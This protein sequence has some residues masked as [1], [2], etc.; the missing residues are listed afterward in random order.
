MSLPAKYQCSSLIRLY[1]FQRQM[2]QRGWV[3]NG[4]RVTGHVTAISI[5]F[6]FLPPFETSMRSWHPPQ[7]LCLCCLA[8]D[9]PM[10]GIS[11]TTRWQTQLKNMLPHSLIHLTN[12]HT[13]KS[14]K[15]NIPLVWVITVGKS[16]GVKL[17]PGVPHRDIKSS[18]FFISRADLT[19]V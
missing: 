6:F 12:S 11:E 15:C 17:N 9:A 13:M 16:V 19:L 7:T 18:F 3:G 2:G 8:Y 14:M 4:N 5:F 10:S 1:K